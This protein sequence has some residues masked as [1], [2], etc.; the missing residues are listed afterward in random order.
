MKQLAV[1]LLVAAMVACGGGGSSSAPTAPT[2]PAPGGPLST[3]IVLVGNVSMTVE[4]TASGVI[5]RSTLTLTE[6][7]HRSGATIASIRV[8][9]SNSTAQRE[10]DIRP[11]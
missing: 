1:L 5:Y 3:A 9:L 10:R 2:S 7:S 6:V 4:P 11:Q 8:N